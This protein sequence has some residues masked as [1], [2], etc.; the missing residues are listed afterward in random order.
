MN[1]NSLDTT[2]TDTIIDIPLNKDKTYS[3]NEK[4][5]I[6]KRIDTIKNKKCYAKLLKVLLENNINISTND[7]GVF[8]NLNHIPDNIIMKIEIILTHYETKTN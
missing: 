5:F 6:S 8:F 3:H 2:T 4:K 7:N 1:T